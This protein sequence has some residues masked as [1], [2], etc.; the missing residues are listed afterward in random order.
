MHVG[1]VIYEELNKVFHTS[2]TSVC[3]GFYMINPLNPP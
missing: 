1:K 3:K 2:T